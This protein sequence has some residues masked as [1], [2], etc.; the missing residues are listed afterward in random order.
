MKQSKKEKKIGT[1]IIL[2]CP[3][4]GG[5]TWIRRDDEEAEGAFE[6]AGCGGLYDPEEMGSEC[7]DPGAGYSREKAQP[8]RSDK[9]FMDMCYDAY[10]MQ[11]LMSH[12]FTLSELMK[13]L[14]DHAVTELRGYPID[15]QS[16]EL[17]V[18]AFM[19]SL[20][21]CVWQQ[22]AENGC[23][24]DSEKEFSSGRFHDAGYMKHL[25]E[26]MPGDSKEHM[27]RWCRITGLKDPEEKLEVKTAAGMI[28]AYRN[29]D[30]GQP[31]IL[32]QVQP[33]GYGCE[34][35]AAEV[36]VY[37]DPEYGAVDDH[38]MDI[39]VHVW[40]DAKTDDMNREHSGVIRREDVFYGLG[41]SYCGAWKAEGYGYLSL[42]SCD[43]GWDYTLY[44]L[45]YDEIDGGQIDD[46]YAGPLTVRD[47]LFEENGWPL[48]SVTDADYD[49]LEENAG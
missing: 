1:K 49:E 14:T 24:Y 38:P 39:R 16:D 3:E 12:G 9:E 41:S 48:D 22:H 43:T 15:D 40:D 21:D 17:H 11:W 19:D 31:G 4:C 2:T 8:E 5:S 46:V 18:R 7:T 45:D 29:T 10:R 32:I 35:D 26:D 20:A 34:I 28:R 25:F 36:C 47:Q 44:D 27:A 37:E 30:P 13:E 42:Q 6:C 33:E 23:I